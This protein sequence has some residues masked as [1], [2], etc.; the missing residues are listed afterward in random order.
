MLFEQIDHSVIRAFMITSKDKNLF[1][2]CADPELIRLQFYG[3]SGWNP[4]CEPD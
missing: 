3:G 2:L 1:S 4:V